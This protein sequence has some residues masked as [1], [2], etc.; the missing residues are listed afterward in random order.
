M[1]A[2]YDAQ[3]FV[4][5]RGL[6][7]PEC[8]RYLDPASPMTDTVDVCASAGDVVCMDVY[9]PHA[10]GVNRTSH[11]RRTVRLVYVGRAQ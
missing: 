8:A 6:L 11:A 2:V 3:G 9:T 1:N 10:S 4:V 5:L 7:R